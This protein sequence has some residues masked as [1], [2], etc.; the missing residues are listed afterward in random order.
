MSLIFD[1]EFPNDLDLWTTERLIDELFLNLI[2]VKEKI[3]NN[4]GKTVTVHKY[5]HQAILN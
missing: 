1:S 3:Y 2:S 4:E 5:Y